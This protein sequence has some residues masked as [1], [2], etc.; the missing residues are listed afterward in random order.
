MRDPLAKLPI[1]YKLPLTFLFLCLV[2]LAV[3][4][5]LVSRFA[6]TAL[7]HEI[8]MRLEAVA[9]ARASS[10]EA[11]RD[12][13][14]RRVQDFA[15]D[16]LIREHLRSITEEG[17]HADAKKLSRHLR[18]NKTPLVDCFLDCSVWDTQGH[19]V[20]GS[21]EKR[22]PAMAEL[23]KRATHEA[24]LWYS[25][26]VPRNDVDPVPVFAINTPVL[27]L[28][29][30]RV[31]GRL[32][33]WVHIGRFLSSVPGIDEQLLSDDARDK[34]IL[35]DQD[36]N[37]LVVP[38]W[39]LRGNGK[40]NQFV[41]DAWAIKV[42]SDEAK[43]TRPRSRRTGL[44]AKT[45][46]LGDSGWSTRVELDSHSAMAPIRDLQNRY[47]GTGL[48]IMI[49]ALVTVL[50]TAGFIVLPLNRLRSAA[51]EIGHGNTGFRVPIM[52]EDEIG[53]VASAFNAMADAVESRT[54]DLE[55]KR[56]ELDLV[57]Q[58]MRDGLCLLGAENE[59]IL[60]NAAA[61]PIH[62]LLLMG[63]ESS[64]QKSC[65]ASHLNCAACLV[66]A[67]KGDQ[68]CELQIDGRT[69]EVHATDLPSR[70]AIGG[71]LLVSRDITDRLKMAE[72][73]SFH[74]RMSVVGEVS[75]A[76]AHE[77]NNPLASI[78]MYN[79]M[80]ADELP[81]DSPFREH[82]EVIG[83]NTK[84]CK[85]AIRDLLDNVRGGDSD[86]VELDL[87]DVVDDVM[88]FLKPLAK[89]QGIQL[90]CDMPERE[91]LLDA[92]EYKLRQ[93]LVNL[94]MNGIQSAEKDGTEVRL[95]LHH[96]DGYVVCDVVDDGPGV[97]PENQS[98]IFD[99]FF[100]TKKPGE[101]TGLGLPTSRRIIEEM[102][103]TL[104]LMKSESAATIFRVRMPDKNRQALP[105]RSAVNGQGKRIG[106]SA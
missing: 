68:T 61:Q 80:M 53:V 52:A 56:D 5:V 58:S 103:G 73:Q 39:L 50:I 18:I 105:A 47:L 71:R 28:D 62:N 63:P 38:R 70:A 45:E 16:G 83:R 15:S 27:D 36:G 82:V 3:G 30:K 102:G 10:I 34:L 9:V 37:D 25:T 72:R 1:K 99:S 97:L 89:S 49:L 31:I 42:R 76:V 104:E 13:L 19:L 35:Q 84:A 66:S 8:K 92:D 22:A 21:R 85:R 59:V 100:T 23:A 94:V 75:S 4:G 106:E 77:I 88:R 81:S 79:Q 60:A 43:L 64:K 32:S 24:G 51:E 69:Y 41:D 93:V 29:G 6:R 101:G 67:Q 98:R 40:N 74:E 17:E 90:V 86:I 96:T 54:L 44:Y 14:G 20:A 33:A 46:E 48:L 12:L 26:F 91:S 55:R 87:I 65:A 57:V 2:M 7:E 78:S 95:V 11:A